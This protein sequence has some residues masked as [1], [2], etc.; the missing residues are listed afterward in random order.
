M[1][2]T[3]RTPSKCPG[4][5]APLQDVTQGPGVD[6]HARFAARVDDVRGRREDEVD[7]LALTDHEVVVEGARVARQVLATARTAAGSRRS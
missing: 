5:A 3:V 6:P 4:R 1:A 2:T 7:P